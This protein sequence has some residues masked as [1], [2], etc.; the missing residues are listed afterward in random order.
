MR[1]FLFKR[2]TLNLTLAITLLTLCLAGVAFSQANAITTNQFIPLAQAVFVPCANGGAGEIILLQGTLHL[3]NHLTLNGNRRVL[4]FHAQPQ[5]A[6][7]VGQ[8]TGDVY[9]GTGVTQEQTS[10]PLT[11]GAFEFTLINNFRIIGPGPDNNLQVHQILHLTA[12][13]NGVETAV[14]ENTSIDCN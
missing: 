4:K 7:G 6:S 8:V 1:K 5:G 10:I 14:V 13:A 2:K 9:H 11:N 3:Q 12:N